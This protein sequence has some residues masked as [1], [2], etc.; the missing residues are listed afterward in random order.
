MEKGGEAFNNICPLSVIA[1]LN[2]C[3]CLLFCASLCH[4][5]KIS[6]SMESNG[7]RGSIIG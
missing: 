4:T 6:L 7:A 1:K 2:L 5:V 3:E